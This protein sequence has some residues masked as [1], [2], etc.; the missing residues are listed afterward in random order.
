VIRKGHLIAGIILGISS[1][2]AFTV[3]VSAEEPQIP[4]WIKNAA[5]FWVQGDVSDQEFLTSIEWMIEKEILK[6]SSSEIEIQTSKKFM[7]KELKFSIWQPEN[8]ERQAISSHPFDPGLLV[9]S[10]IESSTFDEDQP[11]TIAVII[12]DLEGLSLEQY[13]EA[14]WN[15]YGDIL[16]TVGK[17][18]FLEGGQDTTA[19]EKDFWYE[20]T[21]DIQLGTS[22]FYPE[23]IDVKLKGMDVLVGHMDDVYTI[24]YLTTEKNYGKHYKEF[25]DILDTFKIL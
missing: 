11:T 20:Y 23:S 17:V 22:M 2:T 21:Y 3:L 7:K 1:F 6:P 25:L 16:S 13:N 4:T 5:M 19:G 12:D 14:Q 24:T 18:E 15:K 9:Y 8:W 10:M